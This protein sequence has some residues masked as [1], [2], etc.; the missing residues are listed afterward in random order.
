MFEI[1]HQTEELI[2]INKPP[3]WLVHRTRIS[4]STDYVLQTLRDQIGQRVYPVHR[5]DRP[6]SGVLLFGLNSEAAKELVV[7]FENREVKKEYLGVVRGYT[8]ESGLIDYALKKDGE[9]ELQEAKT[10]FQLLAKTELP[11]PVGRYETARYSLVKMTPLTGRMHQLRR[12]FAHIRHPIL[13]D[14]KHGDW[15]HNKMLKENLECDR[16]LLHAIRLQIKYR[17]EILNLEAS[18]DESFHSA[19]RKLELELRHIDV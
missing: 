11:I 14:R 4:E 2:A 13:G 19:L 5:L 1:L 12:H 15:R 8:D 9:G 3:G 10:E 6:T 16:M 17:G 18:L 7:Q